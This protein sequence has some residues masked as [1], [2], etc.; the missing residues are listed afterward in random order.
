M[1]GDAGTLVDIDRVEIPPHL[2]DLFQ[3]ARICICVDGRRRLALSIQPEQIADESVQPNGD[4][5]GLDVSRQIQ[6]FVDSPLNDICQNQR[7]VSRTTV[8]GCGSHMWSSDA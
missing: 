4:D 7:V 2:G 1:E 3:R 6:Q 8:R 5:V